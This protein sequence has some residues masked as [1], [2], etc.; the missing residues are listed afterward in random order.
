MGGVFP[1]DITLEQVEKVRHCTG[2]SYEEARAALA[3]CGG[4]VLDAVILLERRGEGQTSGGD[5]S[6]RAPEAAP[7]PE[8]DWHWP[9]RHE[10]CRGAKKLL[11]NCLAIAL[12]VWR[13]ETMTSSVP[14]LIAAAL[15]LVAPYGVAVLILVGLCTGYRVHITGRGTENWGAKVN[16]TLDQVSDTVHDAFAQLR[17]DRGRHNR[18]K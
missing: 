5:Y 8:G 17:R 15:L 12:E 4:N 14:L 7:E 11:A 3:A 13:G 10:V 2:C 6:T 18:K 1:L 9:T 16:Q